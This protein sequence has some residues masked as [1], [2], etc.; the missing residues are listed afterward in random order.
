MFSEDE[1][2]MRLRVLLASNV[3]LIAVVDQVPE[4]AI[5]QPF[6]IAFPMKKK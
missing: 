1:L 6:S 4:F 3:H 2:D 5:D